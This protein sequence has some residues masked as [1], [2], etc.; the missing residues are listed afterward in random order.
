MLKLLWS[1]ALTSGSSGT[2]QISGLILNYRVEFSQD[3]S[4]K[5]MMGSQGGDYYP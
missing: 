1:Q 4:P 3:K 2:M 5:G